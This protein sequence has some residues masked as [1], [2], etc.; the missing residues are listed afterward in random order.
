MVKKAFSRLK[1][2]DL[3][4]DTLDQLVEFQLSPVKLIIYL[5]I[6]IFCRLKGIDALMRRRRNG[7]QR[8]LMRT[9]TFKPA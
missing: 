2:H 9:K 4:L 5:E 7:K 1:P 6:C 8:I 3:N